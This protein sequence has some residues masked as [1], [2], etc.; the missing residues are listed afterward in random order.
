LSATEVQQH[1]LDPDSLL[2]E[3]FLGE[4]RSYVWAIDSDSL[5][6]HEL[7]R[8]AEIDA[9]AKRLYALLSTSN[10]TAAR[11]KAEAASV[12]GRMLMGTVAEKLGRKRLIIVADGALQYL[13]FAALPEPPAAHT[14]ERGRTSNTHPYRS[15]IMD[16]EIVSLPSAS[17]LEVLRQ[18]MNGRKPA[19]KMIAVFADPVFSSDDPR[20]RQ[21]QA[22]TED[23]KTHEQLADMDTVTSKNAILERSG[24]ESGLLNFDRLPFSRREAEGILG[25]IHD[26]GET[27]MALDFQA[28]RATATA[29]ELGRYRIV[30]FASHALLNARHPELSGVVL[31][32]VDEEGRPQ[33][34][35]LRAH[36]IYNL[37]LGADLVVLSA[38]QT[39]LG[40]EVRGEGLVGLTRGFMYAGAPRVVASLWK[41]PDNATAELMKQFYKGLL[42][43][44]L[45]PAA[46]LR[47]AQIAIQ[48]EQQWSEPYYWAGFVLQGEWK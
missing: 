9:A 39:A 1:L 32:L 43:E 35:F 7:P 21:G 23:P 42:E 31:S 28:N 8:R 45:R 22:K 10:S 48:K 27:L 30:H 14:E 19:T 2:L 25:F 37:K 15:L 4:R 29:E 18:G 12:L 46:A 5:V 3:Y 33:D 47:S 34:G 36:E 11:A 6:S 41:V 40:K 13:P 38:C 44:S 20:V 26:D 16:H 17:T 24:K